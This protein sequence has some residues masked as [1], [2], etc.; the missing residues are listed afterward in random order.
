[1]MPFNI[2]L[3]IQMGNFIVAW[4]VLD[5]FFF[6]RCVQEVKAEDAVEE[7]L[8]ETVFV[9][10]TVLKNIEAQQMQVLAAIRT[11]FATALPPVSRDLITKIVPTDE[12]SVS[13]EC[14][15]SQRREM[16]DAIVREMVKR[17]THV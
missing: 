1:M 6:R 11:Q 12:F 8:R 7:A 3:L 16:A 10:H 2:T 13:L 15:V 4:K 14:P 17:I 5:R 9:Q